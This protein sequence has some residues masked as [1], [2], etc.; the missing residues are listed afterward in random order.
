[1][2]HFGIA[3]GVITAV[4]IGGAVALNHTTAS[5]E[6]KAKPVAGAVS[7]PQNTVVASASTDASPTMAPS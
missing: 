3:F 1:V 7:A 5:H 4:A 2:N 6:I